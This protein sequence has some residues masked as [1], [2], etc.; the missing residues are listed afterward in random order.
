[1]KNVKEKITHR[2]Y[3]WMVCHFDKGE[4][5]GVV[6]ESMAS[7]GLWYRKNQEYHLNFTLALQ[8][9]LST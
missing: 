8:G 6:D 1:M 9:T 4:Y 5:T 3:V 7:G 2:V